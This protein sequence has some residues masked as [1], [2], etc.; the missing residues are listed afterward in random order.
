MFNAVD[1]T[2]IIEDAKVQFYLQNYVHSTR[3]QQLP[4]SVSIVLHMYGCN[5]TRMNAGMVIH[6]INNFSIS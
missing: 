1:N 3:T 2:L 6:I 5:C 4:Y